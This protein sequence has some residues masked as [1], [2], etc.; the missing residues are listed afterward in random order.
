MTVVFT[1]SAF[2]DLVSI[3]ETYSEEGVP[4]IGENFSAKSLRI[5]AICKATQILVSRFPNRVPVQFGN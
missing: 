5:S 4:L 1:Q 3:K 2:G